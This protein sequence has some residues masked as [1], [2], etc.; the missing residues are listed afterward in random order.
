MVSYPVFKEVDYSYFNIK[1]EKKY[2]CM[3]FVAGNQKQL[4]SVF[5]NHSS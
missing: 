3:K 5:I 2:S 4:F 1:K